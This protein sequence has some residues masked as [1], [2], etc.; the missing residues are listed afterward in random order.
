MRKTSPFDYVQAP[1]LSPCPPLTVLGPYISRLGAGDISQAYDAFV[2]FRILSLCQYSPNSVI[3]VRRIP[4]VRLTRHVDHPATSAFVGT[5]GKVTIFVN[6]VRSASLVSAQPECFKLLARI[7]GSYCGGNRT[8][9]NPWAAIR[10]HVGSQ[11]WSPRHC[12]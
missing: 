3:R 5:A 8:L 12:R 10:G 6:Y 1:S 2:V 7:M 4:F 9:A 11:C